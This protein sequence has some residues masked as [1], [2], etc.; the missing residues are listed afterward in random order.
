MQLVVI[1]FTYRYGRFEVQAPAWHAKKFI[2]KN[3]VEAVESLGKWFRRNGVLREG[4]EARVQIGQCV[5]C[6]NENGNVY[7]GEACQ[8]STS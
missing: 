2:G 6:R 3:P 7:V 8:K 5:G 4:M 1:N